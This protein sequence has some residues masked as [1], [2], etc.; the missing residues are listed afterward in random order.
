M[1]STSKKLKMGG[2]AVIEGVM[3]RAED[4]WA[5]AVRTPRGEIVVKREPWR[6]I[7]KRLRILDLPVLRGAIILVETLVLGV[8][9]LSFSA[10]VTAEKQ[11]GRENGS[12]EGE[13]PADPEKKSFWWTLSLVS[14]VFLSLLLGLAVFFYL[15]LLVTEMLSI[16]SPF[17]FNVVDGSLRI[18]VFLGYLLFISRW[19]E[20]GRVFEYHG[21]EHQTIAAFEARKE[22]NWENI[23]G[24]S[25]FHP[26]CGT[27]F[28]LVLLIMSI[29]VFMFFG[30]PADWG[31][32]FLRMLIIPIIGGI[33]YEFIKLSGRF[34]DNIITRIVVAPGLWLQK[35]T[36]RSPDERQ[37]EVAVAALKSALDIDSFPLEESPAVSA[38]D[39]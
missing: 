11:A 20:I 4:N 16:S 12:G 27:S 19:K 28:I 33:S 1:L 35:I 31:E 7:G 5:V 9:A 38:H 15:P 21:A 26:R 17:W 3:M 22:L 29:F 39:G 13:N 25:R 32:R 6:S 34:P 8:K 2:Q 30:K 36:T 10:E 18:V 23:K 24:H 37:V 14:T